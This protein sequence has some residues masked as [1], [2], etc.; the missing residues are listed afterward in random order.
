MPLQDGVLV[1]DKPAGMTSH[2]VVARVRRELKIKRVG[3]GGTLDP[4]ATGVLV[5]GV[6]RAARLLSYAQDAPKTYVAA[7][8]LGVVTSTQDASGEIVSERPV[9]VTEADLKRTLDELSG[10][11]EQVPPMVSAVKVGGERLYKKALRGEE[12]E[13][14]PRL[15][16]I[17]KIDLT[18]FDPPD[19][20]LSVTC[21]A[22]TYVRTLIH[23]AGLGLGCGAHLTSLRRTASG[24]FSES[25]AIS[26]DAVSA[27]SLRPPLDV[28]AHLTRVDVT[29]EVGALVRHGRKL[30]VS[31]VADVEGDVAIVSD[32]ALLAVYTRKGS[33]L[34]PERVVGS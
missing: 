32:G 5:I 28:V 24:G 19:F 2:D 13:R 26:L 33:E 30:P 17:Y 1:V 7:G 12:V 8:R 23:D 29:D 27:E 34:V 15:V 11:I 22:G 20:S 18:S 10:E 25:D 16:N 21:S 31:D 14:R 3:H 9:S 6:G 4:D